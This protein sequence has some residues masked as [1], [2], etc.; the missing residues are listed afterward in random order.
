[1][2]DASLSAVSPLFSDHVYVKPWCRV[3]PYAI[4]C[5]LA[6]VHFERTEPSAANAAVADSSRSAQTAPHALSPAAVPEAVAAELRAHGYWGAAPSPAPSP[7]PSPSAPAVA[8][9]PAKDLCQD[10]F[11]LERLMGR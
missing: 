2:Q 7:S 9:A 10:R 3:T 8:A 4:G 11:T 5:A 1:M 6:F